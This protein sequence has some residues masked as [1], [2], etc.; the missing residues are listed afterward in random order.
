MATESNSGVNFHHH[1]HHHYLRAQTMSFQSSAAPEIGSYYGGHYG[2]GVNMNMN[3]N[4]STAAGGIV[5]SGAP[6]GVISSSSNNN[7][8]IPQPASAFGSLL[9]DSVPG[10]KQAGLAVEWSVEEQYKLEEGLVK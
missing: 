5:F 9:L 6:A 4:V 7:S 8:A 3:V 1:H 10:L 2:H